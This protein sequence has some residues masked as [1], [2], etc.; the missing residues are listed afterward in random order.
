MSRK[1]CAGEGHR[2]A[3][4]LLPRLLVSAAVT[5]ASAAL[6][7]L[8]HGILPHDQPLA[9]ATPC[10]R[11]LVCL[12]SQWL[13]LQI[14]RDGN[15]HDEAKCMCCFPKAAEAEEQQCEMQTAQFPL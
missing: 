1:S 3:L 5:A 15:P 7:L 13:S 6:L 8:T 10:C 11:G 9:A 14:I 4:L 12:S 2:A